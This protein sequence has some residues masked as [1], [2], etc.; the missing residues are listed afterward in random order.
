MLG[1]LLL[2][3]LCPLRWPRCL[4]TELPNRRLVGN[5]YEIRQVLIV[6]LFQN[7]RLSVHALSRIFLC[8]TTMGR[9]SQRFGRDGPCRAG[10]APRPLTSS[11]Q[12]WRAIPLTFISKAQASPHCLPGLWGA[13][14]HETDFQL[15][16]QGKTRLA[17]AVAVARPCEPGDIATTAL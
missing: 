3:E 4:A 11:S 2:P 7:P 15:V 9:L 14:P 12:A 1:C 5:L 16:F 8:Q 6:T 13:P 17:S 10:P